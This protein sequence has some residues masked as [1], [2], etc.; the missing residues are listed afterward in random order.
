MA[1]YLITCIQ[2]M[3]GMRLACLLQKFTAFKSM[4]QVSKT[5]TIRIL[6]ARE[7]KDRRSMKKMYS[8][9]TKLDVY[10]KQVLEGWSAKLAELKCKRKTCLAQMLY[11]FYELLELNTFFLKHIFVFH[12]SHALS[13]CRILLLG[14]ITAPTVRAISFLEAL[15]CVKFGQDVFSKTQG[16]S[17]FLWLLCVC[18]GVEPIEVIGSSG[19]PDDNHQKSSS[20]H[21]NES[22][23]QST[24]I[25]VRPRE[26]IQ[27]FACS[28][29]IPVK[30][31]I[32]KTVECFGGVR[33]TN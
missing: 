29:D 10:R 7:L 32:D 5:L 24:F 13:W 20:N 11:L 12:P 4:K 15:A 17:F 28:D 22:I 30:S 8:F 19:E 33:G 31:S 3:E 25:H 6:A 23:T 26:E 21:D 16:R 2:D 1:K 14:I 9:L 18:F 27:S